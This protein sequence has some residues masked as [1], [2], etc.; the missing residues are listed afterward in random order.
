[1]L[2]L[3]AR[4]YFLITGQDFPAVLGKRALPTL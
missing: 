4:K 1:M 2:Y 3:V